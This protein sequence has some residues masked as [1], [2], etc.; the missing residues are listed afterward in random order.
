MKNSLLILLFLG[1]TSFAFVKIPNNKIDKAQETNTLTWQTSY[2]DAVKLA[3]KKKKPLLV[4]F[5][6]SDWCGPCKMLHADLF[7]NEEFITL[8]N[9][10]LILYKADF[11]RNGGSVVTPEQKLKNSELQT[12]FGVGGFP[13]VIV[14]N[15]KDEVIGKQV[16]YN[17][18]QTTTYHL[19]MIND[20]IENYK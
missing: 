13:T 4:F 20:A 8:A 6:G 19:K 14:L 9:K 17:R 12:Q 2:D 7:E 15:S 3:K 5:T 16:G 11:P 10:E 1:L 18:K